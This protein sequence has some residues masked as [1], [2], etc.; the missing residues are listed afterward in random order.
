MMFNVLRNWVQR[1]FSDE[2]AVVL[3]VL[4]F[5]AFT[6]VLTLGGMLAPVLAGLVLAFLMHGLVGLLERLRMPEVAAVGVVFTL[7]IG[8][9]LVFLLVLVPLLW[10]QLI[11]LFNEAPGMLAKWQSVLLLLPERYPHLVSDEQVLL[12]IEVARGEVG[13]I[14]QLALTFSISS[15]PLLVNLMIYLVLVPIL[16]FFF[17]KD[18]HVIGRWARGYLPRERALLNRVADEM[19]R[20]IAN[21]IRGKVIEIF[22]CGGVTYIA[23]VALGLNYAALL[24][25]LVGISVVVPYVGAVVVTVPVALIGLFQWG[26]SDQFIYLMIAHGVIQALDG[27]VLVPLLFSEAVNLHPVAIICAVL[28]FGG[29]WGFW[30]IFFAI[31]LA[32]LFKAVLDA[33]P[34]NEPTVAPLL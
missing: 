2:E 15:L 23:F 19:K 27:N 11:T 8:A 1:Y 9:L 12:A 14:G 30:G 17:L 3:A 24:A 28:L 29:L 4:L 34:R 32:T 31:P 10:H 7:F 16:V 6:L 18:R 26:W 5:V 13:K 20:Q 21:Y 33:W 25:M 22:I